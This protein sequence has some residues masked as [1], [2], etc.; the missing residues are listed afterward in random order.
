MIP[1]LVLPV[2]MLC[3]FDSSSVRYPRKSFFLKIAVVPILVSTLGLDVVMFSFSSPSS[4]LPYTII[5]GKFISSVGSKYIFS[6][7]FNVYTGVKPSTFC[8][9]S[10]DCL[11]LEEEKLVSNV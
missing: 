9:S 7:S 10:R 5:D 4:E 2:I 6:S 1:S 11:I 8:C 3:T